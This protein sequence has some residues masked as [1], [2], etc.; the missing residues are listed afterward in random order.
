MS[1]RRERS[2]LRDEGCGSGHGAPAW[3]T[4]ET[5]AG[6]TEVP[7]HTA[8]LALVP[9]LNG[10]RLFRIHVRQMLGTGG[11]KLITLQRP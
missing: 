3:G 8:C 1:G 7:C 10:A 4:E 6:K 9:S 11:I 2:A 5:A